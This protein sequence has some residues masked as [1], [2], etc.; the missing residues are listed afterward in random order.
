MKM[1]TSFLSLGL[2]GL[3][4]CATPAKMNTA[5]GRPEVTV[6]ASIARVRSVTINEFVNYGWAPTKTEGTQLVFEHAGTTT[7]SFVM[8]LMTNEPNAQVQA[9]VTLIESGKVVRAVGGLTILG[10]NT[11]GRQ[12]AVEWRGGYAAYQQNLDDI[13]RKAEA[14]D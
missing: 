10:Q 11:F 8:G 7:Q 14:R 12:T 9:T 3:V 1:K 5:S 13:K 4:G 6:N 2:I